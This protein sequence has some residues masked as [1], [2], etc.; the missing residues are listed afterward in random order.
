[1]RL[2]LFVERP[3]TH[4]VFMYNIIYTCTR[5]AVST[6]LFLEVLR[7]GKPGQPGI[8]NILYILCASSI[9]LLYA[10]ICTSQTRPSD[11]Y[12]V[13]IMYRN[14]FIKPRSRCVAFLTCERKI[15]R[16]IIP[17]G[18]GEYDEDAY[19]YC[20]YTCIRMY[21]PCVRLTCNNITAAGECAACACNG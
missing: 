12:A 3:G 10:I 9:N 8:Y 4:R 11:T 7:D 5:T 15:R 14:I 6:G 1:M 13:I 18:G 16:I 20:V 17:P 21:T 19:I 2:E